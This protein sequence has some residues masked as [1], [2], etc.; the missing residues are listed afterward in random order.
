MGKKNPGGLNHTALITGASRGIGYALAKKLAEKGCALYLVSLPGENL[1]NIAKE[2][3]SR[4]NVTVNYF[5][6]QLDHVDNCQQVF[7]DVIMRSIPVSILVNNAG[8]GSSG[9]FEDFPQSFYQKQL[10]VNMNAVVFLTHL[11]LPL[12]RQK[13]VS[14]LLNV[15]SLGAFFYIPHKEV[16]I[17]SKSFILS[18]S[19]SLSIRFR[20]SGL[21]ISV[22]CPGPVN[23]NPRLHKANANMSGLAQK[24]V[25]SP[26]QIARIAI[27]GLLDGKEV[28]IPGRLNR[29]LLLLNHIIP[30]PFK[31]YLIRKEMHKQSKLGHEL[32]N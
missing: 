10:G 6:T 21:N 13:P 7:D 17:A 24:T 29:I 19:K 3:S 1:E 5:E 11:F 12:L 4:Y 22:L 30:T 15:S 8:I 16:Y 25:M 18:F 28:I 2:L 32:L 20:G 27:Q 26:E 9:V 23:T 31:N 14:Y